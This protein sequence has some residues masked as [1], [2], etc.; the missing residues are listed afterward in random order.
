MNS[1]PDGEHICPRCR[2]GR[3]AECSETLLIGET[4]HGESVWEECAC[5]ARMHRARIE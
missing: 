5:H 2:L 4:E 1:H 3:H